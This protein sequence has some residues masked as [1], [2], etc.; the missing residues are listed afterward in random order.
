MTEVEEIRN[1]LVELS[2]LFMDKIVDDRTNFDLLTDQIMKL[3]KRI[4]AL[5][6]VVVRGTVG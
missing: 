4:D 5:H 2:D 1:C 3:H 6:I